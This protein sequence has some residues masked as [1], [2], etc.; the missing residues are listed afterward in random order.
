MYEKNVICWLCVLIITYIVTNENDTGIVFLLTLCDH[1]NIVTLII[2]IFGIDRL[3]VLFVCFL[4]SDPIDRFEIKHE[5]PKV[6]RHASN[7]HTSY[8]TSDHCPEFRSYNGCSY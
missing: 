5:D 4:F 1:K 3:I 8:S 6:K 7:D 2:S